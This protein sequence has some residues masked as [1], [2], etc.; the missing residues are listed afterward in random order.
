MSWLPA[1]S[2]V[3]FTCVCKPWLSLIR[4]STSA[5][6]T[7]KPPFLLRYFSLPPDNT[8]LFCLRSD[9]HAVYAHGML[10]FL[11]P[12]QEHSVELLREE[13][14]KRII[15]HKKRMAL[16][17][18]EEAKKLQQEDYEREQ[19]LLDR[20]L[21]EQTLDTPLSI[22]ELP[23]DPKIEEMPAALGDYMVCFGMLVFPKPGQ[24]FT[25]ELLREERERRLLL[26]KNR[27]A[28]L[29][30]E[31]AEKL[32]KE[33]Y[34]RE[35][36]LLD[37]THKERSAKREKTEQH[38]P[39]PKFVELTSTQRLDYEERLRESGGFDVGDILAY[40]SNIPV[41]PFELGNPL[42][43]EMIEGYAK[44]ALD[45]HN[46]YNNT[47][48]QFV[49]V[50]KANIGGYSPGWNYYITSQVKDMASSGSPT[51]N[52]QA[53]VNSIE[54]QEAITAISPEP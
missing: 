19:R 8:R 50:L 2:L 1:K 37:Q 24:R 7:A 3:R 47:K 38:H 54:D 5:H 36:H 48:Y 28:L 25:M 16:L 44:S 46:K 43:V 29:G 49:K 20:V 17:G 31:E 30:T 23:V 14:E 40:V 22:S 41:R 53:K 45:Q 10:V 12:G 39:G 34:E 11:K 26:H 18:E 27:I 32:Q 35:Q 33:D 9:A 13:K 15:L 52:F 42:L 6:T 4:D 51:L 21:E